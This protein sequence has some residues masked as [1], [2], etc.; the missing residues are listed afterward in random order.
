VHRVISA[1]VIMRIERSIMVFLIADVN[2]LNTKD[3]LP[4]SMIKKTRATNG[5]L[6]PVKKRAP[7]WRII[8]VDNSTITELSKDEFL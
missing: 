8:D 7:N 4:N 6:L 2:L 3:P 1:A 5:P